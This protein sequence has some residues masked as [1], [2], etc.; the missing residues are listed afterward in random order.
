VVRPQDVELA[1]ARDQL[2]SQYI[3][4]ATVEA[5]VYTG[6]FER[7]RVKPIE[8]SALARISAAGTA[9]AESLLEVVR[10]QHEQ[11]TLPLAV[12]QTVALGVR[13]VHVLP[14]PLTS[15]TICA[16]SAAEAES[17]DRHPLLET[18][19]ARMQT[20]LTFNLDAALPATPARNEPAASG[21]AVIAAGRDAPARIAVLI[22]GGVGEV[23]VLPAGQT[24][25]KRVL[26][27]WTNDAARRGTLAVAASLLRHVPA[28]ALSLNILPEGAPDRDRHQGIFSVLDARSEGQLVHRID[29]RTELRFGDAASELE[30][31]LALA[32]EQM[33]ILGV[34]DPADL[35]SRFGELLGAGLKHPVLI[36]CSSEATSARVAHVA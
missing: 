2:G 21:V 32:G 24:V 1:L 22:R 34:S 20:R 27:H 28:E 18:L 15:F 23:L 8:G 9:A 19:V 29:V 14:T 10:T 31:E 30:R 7:L 3:G 17:L 11:A 35:E 12:R 26:I 6:A 36:V 33:L 16:A 5:V 13:S 4:Q 25:P